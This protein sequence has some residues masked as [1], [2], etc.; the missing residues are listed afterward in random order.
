[1]VEVQWVG[2]SPSWSALLQGRVEV[3]KLILYKP[4]LV[5]ETDADGVPN[6]EFKPGA[7]GQQP[8]GAPSEGL[9][10]AVGKLDII[11]GTLSYTYPLTGKTI[12]AEQVKATASVGSFKGPFSID[13][14]ATVNGVPLSLA[15]SVHAPRDDG[16][17]DAKLVVKVPSGHLTFDGRTSAIAPDATINGH[18]QVTTGGLTD[19]ISALV[20]AIGEPLPAFDTSVVGSFA[21]DGGI[22]ISPTQARDQRLQGLSRRRFG[23]RYAGADATASSR[24]SRASCRCARSISTNGWSF[25]PSPACSCRRRHRR[26][27]G[28][29]RGANRT[30]RRLRPSRCAPLLRHLRP[31]PRRPPPACRRFPPQL[32]VDLDLDIAETTFRKGTIR[33]L[34]HGAGD[35]QRRD[36][37]AA[38]Q[39]DLPGEMAVQADA[40][41]D[42]PA[43]R[44]APSRLAGTKLRD[45][46]A[47][48]EVDAS[49]V[50]KDKLQSLSV[51]GKVAST[52]GSLNVAD[53]S[54][55]LDGQPAKA[56]G[57]LSFGPPFTLSATL[58]VDR[59]DLDAY[60]PKEPAPTRLAVAADAAA[61]APP[62]KASARRTRS[63][64]KFQLKSKV[65]KLVYRRETL[66]GVEA[67]ATMQGNLLTLDTIKVA[68]LLGAKLDLKGTVADFASRPRFDLTFNAT[69]P[70]TEK[71]LDYAQL[72]KFING[73]IGPSS[74]SGGVAGTFDALTLRNVTRDDARLDGARHRRAQD[75]RPGEL[76]LPSSRFRLPTLA[77]WSRSASGRAPTTSVGAIAANGTLKGTD[78]Q[79][80]FNG[81][82]MRWARGRR[83][84]WTPRSARGRNITAKLRV[85]GTF[86]VDQWLG[87]SAHPPTRNG[88]A[89]GR[90]GAAAG[91]QGGCRDRQADRS[92]GP[93]G[94]RRHDLARDQRPQHRFA[95]SP[96][97]TSKRRCATAC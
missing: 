95:R 28:Q 9:H 68:D 33:D 84:R 90:R 50:P 42:G 39:G 5:L 22:E 43:R 7:G 46:L 1:M 86:D 17:N 51:K 94:V 57:A 58:D 56:G 66:S 30:L 83:A 21:F 19:F 96:M 52:A 37:R 88:A 54:L 13:G 72:P 26:R 18:L 55:E 3:G 74:A 6:W 75:R 82:S 49:G 25:W 44:P 67:N 63:T 92:V 2:A 48:L 79:A 12:K 32:G 81:R 11:D 93:Q 34:A 62:L 80:T 87:V 29:A 10:L 71:L 70:D 27:C 78:K 8:A 14:T 35:P 38:L 73:K 16:A 77:A 40:A 89:G 31:S 23:G 59:F 41:V 91:A 60:M 4:V 69:V 45:T 15:V 47:W 24:R 20:R 61:T 97:P 64:P 76:R 65:G 36:H 85:P 53:A